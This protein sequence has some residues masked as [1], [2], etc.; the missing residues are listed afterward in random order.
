[1][2]ETKYEEAYIAFQR[3]DTHCDVEICSCSQDLNWKG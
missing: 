3:W 1:M 2:L